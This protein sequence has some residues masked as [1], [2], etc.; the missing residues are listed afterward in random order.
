MG[1][2]RNSS[3]SGGGSGRS[4]RSG[5]SSSGSSSGIIKYDRTETFREF[6]I[7]RNDYAPLQESPLTRPPNSP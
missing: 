2:D 5:S 1:S 6:I 7:I 3:S 4:S